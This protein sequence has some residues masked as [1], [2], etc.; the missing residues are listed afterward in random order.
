M[1]RIIALIGVA[2]TLLGC[3][4]VGP[5]ARSTEARILAM[6]DSMM[7]W[8][9]GQD[10][11]IPHVIAD[12]LGQPVM[13]RAMSGAHVIYNLPISGAA[14]LQISNQ[15]VEGNW[16][17]VVLNGGGNDL[18]LGCNCTKC[19]ARMTKMISPDG[20]SGRIPDM[21]AK[22]RATGA[23]VVYLGYLRSPGRGSIIEHCRD[24]GEELERR[25]ERM[26]E[27]MDGVHFLSVAEIVPHGDRSYHA[28]DM[29][30]PSAKG[31]REIGERA[32]EIIR[33]ASES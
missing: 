26:A 2:L 5:N 9:G 23:Q 11:A 3:A 1:F 6:G 19:N 21:V 32:A 13:T 22:V 10:Q 17:W 31:S 7:A 29:I 25:L 28:L 24:D 30:H 20:A 15:Y 14:G 12:A 16:D 27:N 4:T 18:W 8:N 33:K